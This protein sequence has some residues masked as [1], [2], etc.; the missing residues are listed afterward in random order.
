MC[1]WD[2]HWNHQRNLII[3]GKHECIDSCIWD[4]VKGLNHAGLKTIASCCGHGKQ[5]TNIMLKDGR[6]IFIMPDWKSARKVSNLFP[7][8]N[9]KEAEDV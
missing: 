3:D 2:G 7:P 5:P 8:I 4:I 9:P 6:E 1:E